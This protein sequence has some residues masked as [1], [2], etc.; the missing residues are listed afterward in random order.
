L[1]N[2]IGR[3]LFTILLAPA[4]LTVTGCHS[5]HID[6]TIENRTGAAIQLLEID[7][8]SASFGINSLA[9]GADTHYRFQVRGSGQLTVQYTT[10]GGHLVQV[11]GPV[12]AERQQGQL[13]IVLLPEGK[14]EF[15][16]HLAPR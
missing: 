13:E 15:V 7:Y 5:Y 16:P 11:T 4:L 6:S 8:P 14:A 9:S 2:Q 1:N 3:R 12:L 10:G